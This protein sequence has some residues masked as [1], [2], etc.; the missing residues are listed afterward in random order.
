MREHLRFGNTP[1]NNKRLMR[2]F[3]LSTVGTSILTN[4]IDNQNPGEAIWRK[5]LRDSANLKQD[6]LAAETEEVIDTLA[7]RALE[8]LMEDNAETNCPR[9]CRIERHLWH[10]RWFITRKQ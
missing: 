9:Q 1:I 10:L 7:E 8:K 2:R 4:L 5:I 3:V 6:E